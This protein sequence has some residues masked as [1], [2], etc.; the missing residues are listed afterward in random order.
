MPL[1]LPPA[2]RNLH[3][4]AARPARSEL[5]LQHSWPLSTTTAAAAARFTEAPACLHTRRPQT[6]LPGSG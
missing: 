5:P 1:R 3:P 6:G 2:L 4:R